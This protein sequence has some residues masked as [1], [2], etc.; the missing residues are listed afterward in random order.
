VSI[1][2]ASTS[3]Y[4]SF[5]SQDGLPLS[6]LDGEPRSN[7]SESFLLDIAHNSAWWSLDLYGVRQ[8]TATAAEACYP[9]AVTIVAERAD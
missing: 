8:T 6:I 3:Q 2:I 1:S 5:D 4:W 7:Y 9:T